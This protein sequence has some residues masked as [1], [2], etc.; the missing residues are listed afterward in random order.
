MFHLGEFSAKSEN[1]NWP[2]VKVP[3]VYFREITKTDY[4]LFFLGK[5]FHI[6][7]PAL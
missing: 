2:I 7:L 4:N 3:R 6:F 1:S 5:A